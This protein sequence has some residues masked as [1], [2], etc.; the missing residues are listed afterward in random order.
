MLYSDWKNIPVNFGCI[1]IQKKKEKKMKK[2]KTTDT[3]SLT[4]MQGGLFWVTLLAVEI[5]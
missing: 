4:Q 5:L 1:E 3:F 2:K